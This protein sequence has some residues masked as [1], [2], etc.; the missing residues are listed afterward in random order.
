VN[1][2]ELAPELA[3]VFKGTALEDSIPFI[4]GKKDDAKTLFELNGKKYLAT[5]GLLSS[6]ELLAEFKKLRVAVAVTGFSEGGDPDF[7]LVV[8]THDSP[9]AGLAARAFITMTPNLRKVAEVGKVQVFQ[10]RSPNINYDPTGVP[11]I[12]ND[13]QPVDGPHE[14]TFAYTPGVFV[15]G[16]SKTAV[17]NVIKRFGGEEK[18]AS[19]ASTELFKEAATTHRKT[20]LFYFVNFPEFLRKFDEANKLRGRERGVEDLVKPGDGAIA[21]SGGE[22]DLLAWFKMTANPKAVKSIAGLVRFRDGGVSATMS[23][24]FDPAHK[25]P[26][27]DFLSG[28]GV[29]VE[30]LHHARM[31]ATF[32]VAA[33]FPEKNRAAAVTGFLDAMAKANGELGRLPSEAVRE[34]EQKFKLAITDGLLAKTWGVTV[35][36]P[37]KQELPKGNKPLPMLVLHTDDAATAGAWE[38]FFPKL[39]GDVAGAATPPQPSS[40]TINGVKVFSLA[41]NALSGNAPIHYARSGSVVAVG[42]DRKLVAAA[43]SADAGKSV[44]GGNKT[45]SPPPADASAFG[46]VSLGEVL[47]GFLER[48]R[49]VGPVVPKEDEPLFM[50]NGN[51]LPENFM[52]ELKK[53]RKAFVESLGSLPPATLTVRRVGNELKIELF[54]SKVQGGGLKAVIDAGATWLDKAGVLMGAGRN[55]FNGFDGVERLGKW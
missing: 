46:V 34:L 30:L 47:L 13:R 21:G 49:P 26:L 5:L 9:A 38:E 15:F 2:A 48:P 32:A 39:M 42:L 12:Q 4:H 19:L 52:E 53:A 50:P 20:G 10:Y 3:S 41:G 22:L 43:T 8:L 51:P 31:P 28:P 27:L 44:V 33:T 17:G 7:A 24:N 54:Q 23:A 14:P 35:C 25:S 6:P 37:A 16:S 11:V 40:E 18:A 55:N 1:P 36:L 45:V 29:K